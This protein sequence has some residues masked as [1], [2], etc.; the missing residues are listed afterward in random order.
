MNNFLT[1]APPAIGDEEIEEV[2]DTLRAGWITTGPKTRQFEED[3]RAAVDAEAAL[4]LNS[5]TAGL[6]LALKVLEIGAGDEVITTPLT[7]A[8]TVNVIEHVSAVPRLADVDPMTL[9]I[10]PA[11]I[12][13]AV[14]SRTKAILVVHFAGHPAEMDEIERIARR[15]GLAI[16]E[17]AAHAFPARYDNRTIG[18]GSNLTSFSFYATKNLTTGE[19]GM[20]TGPAD[21]IAKARTLSLHGMSRDAWRRYEQSGTWRYDVVAPGFKYNMSD[22]QASIGLRQLRKIGEMHSRRR[23]IAIQYSRAF[24]GLEALQVPVALPSVDHAWHL[25]VLRLRSA[26]GQMNRDDLLDRLKER[27][28]GYSVHFIPIHTH[29]FY[30]AKYGWTDEEYPVAYDNFLRMLSLPLHPK[31]DASDVE[32]VIDAV[33]TALREA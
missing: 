26:S 13:A 4:A 27:G 31:L 19:G 8:A 15:Y 12:E 3:F 23:Q 17:D 22:I 6:H 2:V 33:R 30:R 16:I 9:N 14:T 18:S 25:Y 32:R 20:L 11:A 21:L 1:F 29:P 5:C 28:I 10:S 24:S 7:F